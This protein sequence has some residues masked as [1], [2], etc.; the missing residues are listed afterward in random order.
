M[1]Q[2][3]RN[4]IVSSD[5]PMDYIIWNTVGDAQADAHEHKTISIPHNL[6]FAPLLFGMYSQDNGQ[7]WT[8][9]GPEADG[10]YISLVSDSQNTG[11]EILARSNPVSIKYKIWAYA[12]ADI[13]AVFDTINSEDNFVIN[14]DYNY[15]KLFS[16]GAW[17]AEESE[18]AIIFQHNLGYVPQIVVWYEFQN[19]KIYD[20][21]S[22]IS[23]DTSVQD[24]QAISVDNNNVYASFSTLDIGG[25][26][27]ILTKVHYRVYAD[28]MEE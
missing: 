27:G 12:Q 19:G 24:Q 21:F 6:G 1:V 14:S 23:D 16:A 17:D 18:N 26:Y 28:S 10:F 20:G 22:N 3:A 7:T 9:F 2:D 5:Y 4:F 11:I 8:P 13:N 15:S 25:D